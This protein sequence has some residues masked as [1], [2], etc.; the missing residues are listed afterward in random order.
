VLV[1]DVFSLGL[2][3]PKAREKNSSFRDFNSEPELAI[4]KFWVI[5]WHV[6]DERFPNSF[7]PSQNN[8]PAIGPGIW[9]FTLAT[10]SWIEL[11]NKILSV[12]NSGMSIPDCGCYLEEGVEKCRVESWQY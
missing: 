9:N 7:P 12:A 10:T 8:S 4:W 6:G 1:V 3:I 2:L 11:L 5:S